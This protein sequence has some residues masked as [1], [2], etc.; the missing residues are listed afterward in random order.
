MRTVVKVAAVSV[1]ARPA[2]DAARAAGTRPAAVVSVAGMPTVAKRAGRIRTVAGSAAAGR[3][4][5][6]V[7]LGAARDAMATLTAVRAVAA[8]NAVKGDAA[9]PTA[10][11]IVGDSTV[12]VTPRAERAAV[13]STVARVAVVM[14]TAVTIVGHSTVVKGDAGMPT[15]VKVVG[16]ST[17]VVTP[18]AERA[19]EDS[20]VMRTVGR[21]VRGSTVVMGINER[22]EADWRFKPT[23]VPGVPG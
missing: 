9:M 19:A 23:G 6:S 17:V 8:S 15:V 4:A 12:V 1:V 11:R 2:P 14:P 20:S 5:P 7:R 13:G 22:S 16:D 18:R 10:E 3:T 21:V